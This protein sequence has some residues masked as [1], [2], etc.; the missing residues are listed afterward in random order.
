M[1]RGQTRLLRS[2]VG[3][4][5]L[6][7]MA[8]M[9]VQSSGPVSA[10]APFEGPVPRAN[11]ANNNPFYL[12][13]AAQGEVPLADRNSG[14]SQ[15]GYRC[16]LELLGQFQAQGAG[17]QNAWY[18][19]CDYFDTK[20]SIDPTKFP[21]GGGN[22][23]TSPGVQVIDG[24]D[25]AHPVRTVNLDT[26]AMDGPWESL[27]VNQKRGLM[28]GVGGFGGDVAGPLYFDVYDVKSDCAHPKLLSSTPTD[29]PNGHE[30]NWAPDGL[31]YYGSSLGGTMAAIDVSDPT[32]PKPLAVFPSVT[33]PG[34]LNH[35]LSLSD[36]GN[37]LYA[38][39]IGG[40]ANG[41]GANGLEIF[42]VSAIQS[43]SAAPVPIHVSSLYWTDGSTAQHTIPIFYG[44]HPYLVFVD[45]GGGNTVG[46]GTSGVPAGASRIIDIA[47][48]LHP[49]IVSVLR[50]EIQTVPNATPNQADIAGNGNF[51]YEA[52][53]CAVDQEVDPT[54]LACGYFQSGIRVF[55][56]RDPAHPAEIAYYNPPAQVQKHGTLN[57]SEHDG[58]STNSQPPNDSTDWC[59]SQIRFYQAPDG[60]Y[61]LWA[62]C[63]DNGFMAL[64]F[65]NA[66]Y[67]LGPTVSVP[68]SPWTVT[69]LP[70]AGVAT[71][72]ILGGGRRRRRA[73]RSEPSSIH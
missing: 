6:A 36:D 12:E 7:G 73:R 68:E 55:D 42:D 35:G 3:A 64:R 39:S 16:N 72:A 48:P 41:V 30:G 29:L 22:G 14:R 32:S 25:P 47:D 66:A 43:R 13:P 21:N 37:T 69:V 61:Q 44:K 60:S 15:L 65:T 31:T 70:L 51:G 54:A 53:Y 62:Q 56:I 67:P 40:L 2:T 58:G 17:W 33:Q 8:T 10:A 23:Q 28:A 20:T 11:C 27:K 46:S 63:Q 9:G 45:E 1:T 52:H 26:P 50:L 5:L 57:G 24:S 49:T 59:A 34:S 4:L 38:T 71:A 19:H 18:D